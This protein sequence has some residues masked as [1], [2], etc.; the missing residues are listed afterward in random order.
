[1]NY[2]SAEAAKLLKALNEQHEMLI[3]KERQ[4]SSFIAALSEDIES[5]RPDY[6]YESTKS[7][8]EEIERKIRAVKHAVNVFNTT[9]KVPGFDMTID[10][11]LVYMPQLSLRKRRLY[12]MADALPKKRE[13][14]GMQSNIIDYR[15]TNYDVA[16]V[17]ADM[18]AA[19]DLLARLQNALDIVNTTEKMEIEF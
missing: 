12:P 1:M 2:T 6:D 4:S 18:T 3:S 15:Y 19:G 5:V 8:L 13:Q 7:Q 10:E 14:G 9:H 16:Q 11:V 17:E